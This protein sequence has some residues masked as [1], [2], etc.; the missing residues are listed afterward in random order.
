VTG[1]A[2]GPPR[3]RPGRT[4]RAGSPRLAFLAGLAAALVLV[5]GLTLLASNRA[6]PGDTLYA[7]K[8]SGEQVELALVHNPQ[9]RGLRGLSF[10]QTRLTE[11]GQLIARGAGTSPG[12]HNGTGGARGTPAADDSGLLTRTLADMDADTRDGAVLVTG[13]AV[14]QRSDQA[15][16]ELARWT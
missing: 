5:S 8:R 15:L 7:V 13:Y 14:Q 10:A 9:E 2:A 4:A 6:L 12:Q 11:V 16:A 3:R 1:R